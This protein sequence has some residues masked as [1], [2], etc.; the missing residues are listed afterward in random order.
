[1]AAKTGRN[2]DKWRKI[3]KVKRKGPWDE[4]ELRTLGP[5]GYNVLL[6]PFENERGDI[7]NF[8]SY[9]ILGN[10]ENPDEVEQMLRLLFRLGMRCGIAMVRQQCTEFLG[11]LPRTEPPIPWVAFGP[12]MVPRK[13]RR[14]SK[15]S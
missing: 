13:P 8:G 12:T 15:K 6:P 10:V 2:L 11:Q 3:P 1:M 7:D 5:L 4:I 14:K 9:R